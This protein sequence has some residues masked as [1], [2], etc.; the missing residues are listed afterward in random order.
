MVRQFDEINRTGTALAGYTAG[1]CGEWTPGHFREF[2]DHLNIDVSKII[3]ANQH[4]TDE[5]RVVGEEDGGSG[6]GSPKGEDYYDAMITD[7]AGLML[8]VHTADCV[9]IVLLDPKRKAAGAVH[10]GWA[11]ASKGIAG[12]TVRKMI[13]TFGCDPGDIVC[14]LGPYNH[15]CC[16]EV[17]E[18][19][20][21]SFQSGFSEDE[22]GRMFK[23][24]DR[25]EKYML[26]LGAAVTIS[27]CHEGV[28]K[29][30]IHDSGHC[31]FHTD[32]FSSW[33][34]TRN[35]KHQILTYIEIMPFFP[36]TA[37]ISE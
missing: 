34:R 15:S 16:Y 32:E 8:C 2:A 31:T 30:N 5:I 21:E 3:V 25:E 18:D 1:L 13:E 6:T 27:L 12:K 28:R 11:G 23:K 22:C 10:S 7:T 20:L 36:I 26:D 9:P 33:R 19:V 35:K 17:G 14:C 29:E 37:N 4:H 24:K